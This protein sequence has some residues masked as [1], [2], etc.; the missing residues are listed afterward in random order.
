MVKRFSVVALTL[1]GG[2]M[3]LGRPIWAAKPGTTAP[4]ALT[5]TVHDTDTNGMACQICSDG[6]GGYVDGTDGVA[7]NIDQYG[8]IIINF[9][10]GRNPLRKLHYE[11][12]GALEGQTVHPPADP[13]NNY[14]IQC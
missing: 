7:A 5:V 13:P 3:L 14:F 1:I 10:T 4:V 12:S 8:N 6:G 2:S 9:Q 11:Y